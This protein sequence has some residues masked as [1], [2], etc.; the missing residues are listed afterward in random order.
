M[1]LALK[2]DHFRTGQKKA[3]HD[4]RACV[5][6]MGVSCRTGW[7]CWRQDG[8]RHCLR[9]TSS[10]EHG[11]ASTHGSGSEAKVDDGDGGDLSG[12]AEAQTQG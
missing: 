10:I 3:R 7:W 12:A 2:A 6:R 11:I 8:G 5:S 1:A 9:I 4:G